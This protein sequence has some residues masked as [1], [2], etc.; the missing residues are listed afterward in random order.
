MLEG[1]RW[2]NDEEEATG[3]DKE[4]RRRMSVRVWGQRGG[5]RENQRREEG[6]GG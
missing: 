5:R 4:E 3:I 2:P 6:G 1:G